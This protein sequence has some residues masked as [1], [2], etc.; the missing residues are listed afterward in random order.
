MYFILLKGPL[1][2]NN[3]FINEIL[4]LVRGKVENKTNLKLSVLA[5]TVFFD[6]EL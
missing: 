1:Q 6:V 5:S 3:G 2:T 4:Y